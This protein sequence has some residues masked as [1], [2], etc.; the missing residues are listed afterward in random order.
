MVSTS[1]GERE[2]RSSFHT[3]STFRSLTEAID[4]TTPADRWDRPELQ[5]LLDRYRPKNEHAPYAGLYQQGKSDKSGRRN[6][7]DGNQPVATA[8]F[9]TSLSHSGSPRARAIRRALRSRPACPF[10]AGTGIAREG[11]EASV[12]WGDHDGG[13]L[14]WRCSRTMREYAKYRG[15]LYAK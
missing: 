3:T 13:G 2:S 11:F 1:R 12:I 5:R 8:A 10:H 4:T 7:N 14:T 6:V 9:E 15:K